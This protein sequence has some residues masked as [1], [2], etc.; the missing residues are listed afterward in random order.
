M[1]SQLEQGVLVV[2]ASGV[3]G[4]VVHLLLLAA[5]ARFS[6]G[7]RAEAAR[8]EAEGSYRDALSLRWAW[9]DNADL[10]GLL[11]R[12]P[13]TDETAAAAPEATPHRRLGPANLAGVALVVAYQVLTAP[14]HAR[15]G[16]RQCVYWPNCSNYAIGALRR[17]RFDV[18]AGLAVRRL[19]ACDGRAE[20]VLL[21]PGGS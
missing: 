15:F 18:A 13:D 20:G 5:V 4:A 17:H 3:A 10:A 9:G 2:V 21:S 1:H 12:I 11:A 16:H 6:R 7:R 8:L 14:R 19:R